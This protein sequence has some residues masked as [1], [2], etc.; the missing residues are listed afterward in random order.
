MKKI[1]DLPTSKTVEA[2]TEELYDACLKDLE[3]LITFG[4][5]MKQGLQNMKRRHPNWDNEDWLKVSLKIKKILN[6]TMETL[7]NLDNQFK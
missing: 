2:R 6:P 3:G 1:V 7:N 5:I 4:T